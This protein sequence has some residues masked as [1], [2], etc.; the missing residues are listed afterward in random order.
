MHDLIGERVYHRI[1]HLP[2]SRVG[3]GDHTLGDG[4]ARAFCDPAAWQG[5]QEHIIIT[6]KLDGTCVSVVRDGDEIIPA[7]RSGHRADTSPYAMHQEFDKYVNKNWSTFIMLLDKGE[8]IVGEWMA[9]AHGIRY[10]RLTD[11]FFAFDIR[12]DREWISYEVLK[13]RCEYV[14]ISVVPL[15]YYGP[16][17]AVEYVQRLTNRS[18]FR[19]K[20]PA[21]GVVLRREMHGRLMDMA[22][23]VRSDHV[24]GL[25]LPG[26]ENAVVSEPVWHTIV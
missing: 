12:R 8:R 22:Q 3:P 24:A 19:N 1:G 9:Q 18:A 26:T 5:S 14:G 23:Y 13:Q 11:F 4:P 20:R 16:Q 10:N 21:E 17:L 15:L 2:G 7:L 6:E 25:Y